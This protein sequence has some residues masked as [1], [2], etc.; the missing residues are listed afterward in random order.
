MLR[1]WFG[2]SL[3]PVLWA[4]PVLAGCGSGADSPG[5]GPNP[6][7]LAAHSGMTGRVTVQ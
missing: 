6:T 2:T 3:V 1:A 4:A 5:P 7:T